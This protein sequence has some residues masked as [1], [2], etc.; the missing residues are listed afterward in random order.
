MLDG[1]SSFGFVS[2]FRN[3]HSEAEFNVCAPGLFGFCGLCESA[4]PP[5]ITSYLTIILNPFLLK[6][7]PMLVM[8]V[9]DCDICPSPDPVM[10]SPH[11][12]REKLVERCS[13][14]AAF[15]S[16][17]M[18]FEVPFYIGFFCKIFQTN[19]SHGVCE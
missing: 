3:G 2:A 19:L 9:I 14:P 11:T 1:V 6:R 12:A 16:V 17:H 7:L 15:R 5:T 8:H 13:L 18:P 4:S 10:S